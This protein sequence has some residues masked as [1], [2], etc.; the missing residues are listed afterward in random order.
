[1]SRFLCLIYLDEKERDSMPE[2]EWQELMQ[3]AITT[4]DDLL[5]RGVS[6][7]AAAL[8]PVRTAVTLHRKRGEKSFTDGPFAETKEQLAGYILVEAP[9]MEAAKA[10]ARSLPPGRLGTVEVRPVWERADLATRRLP[11]NFVASSR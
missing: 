9:D 3:E 8:Q 11:T 1:M 2:E 10:I 5:A 4:N 7:G 6:L